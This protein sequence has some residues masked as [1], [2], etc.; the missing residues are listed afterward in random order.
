MAHSV[1]MTSRQ[2]QPYIYPIT[3]PTGGE[4]AQQYSEL[5]EWIGHRTSIQLH[6]AYFKP[7]N[8]ATANF[9]RPFLNLDHQ[10]QQ[11]AI[12][13]INELRGNMPASPPMR[14]WFHRIR[15][16]PNLYLANEFMYGKS[17]S[18]I[19]YQIYHSFRIIFTR[20]ETMMDGVHIFLYSPTLRAKSKCQLQH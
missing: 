9:L 16:G 3:M 18:E 1:A 11:F 4:N 20:H 19:L 2:R 12:C 8:A 7:T 13:L 14:V 5:F 15:E 10:V 17:L 6:A